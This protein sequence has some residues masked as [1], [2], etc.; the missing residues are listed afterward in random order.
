[1][2]VI[3]VFLLAASFAAA[4]ASCLAFNSAAALASASSFAFSSAAALASAASASCFA[5]SSA[6]A[7]SAFSWLEAISLSRTD[8]V[9]TIGGE[10]TSQVPERSANLQRKYS[11]FSGR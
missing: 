2:Q 7:F 6:A 11:L 4:S 8:V 9:S 10:K 1:M 5:F 3:E